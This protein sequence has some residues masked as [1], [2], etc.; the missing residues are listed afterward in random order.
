MSIIAY[1]SAESDPIEYPLQDPV[2]DLSTASLPASVTVYGAA[3]DS[4]NPSATFSWQWTLKSQAKR[5]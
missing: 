2:V 3:V 4:S 5:S 1:A